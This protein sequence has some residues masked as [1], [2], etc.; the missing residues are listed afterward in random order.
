VTVTGTALLYEDLALGTESAPPLHAARAAAGADPLRLELPPLPGARL[1]PE[2]L[3]AL[4]ALY[5]AARLEEMGVLT[6]AEGLV[7]ERAVLQVPPAT[8]AKLEDLARRQA[9]SLPRERRAQLFARLFGLGVGANADPGTANAR[10]EPMLAALCSA[11][12]TAGP[13]RLTPVDPDTAAVARAATDLAATAGL[14]YAGSVG[15]AVSPINEQLQRAVDLIADAGIGALVRTR[16]FW[17]TLRAFLAPNTPDLRRLLDCGRHGQRVLLW[18]SDVAPIL[19]AAPSAS[20]IS[21]GA[22]VSAAAWLGAMGLP[23]P[24]RRQGWA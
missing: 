12:V 20:E 15:L 9:R 23:L 10:F 14:T 21:S 17:P 22:V 7:A 24:T 5:F 2:A 6:V 3:R 1:A 18:L 13:R 16:G 4:G 11:L 8:A 19:D